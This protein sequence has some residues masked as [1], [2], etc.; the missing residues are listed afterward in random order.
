[1]AKKINEILPAGTRVAVIN[2]PSYSF[3]CGFGPPEDKNG[4]RF[5]DRGTIGEYD[6]GKIDNIIWFDGSLDYATFL[7]AVSENHFK[8][9]S[10][11]FSDKDRVEIWKRK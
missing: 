7:K 6:L 8:V 2:E 4:Y 1:M 10:L 11:S 3:L 9:S 5:I